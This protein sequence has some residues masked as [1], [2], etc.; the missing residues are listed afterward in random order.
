MAS[1]RDRIKNAEHGQPSRLL[2][3]FFSFVYNNTIL[4]SRLFGAARNL[5]SECFQIHEPD[6]IADGVSQQI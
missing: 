2:D 3:V 1:Y 6:L 5:G 4:I